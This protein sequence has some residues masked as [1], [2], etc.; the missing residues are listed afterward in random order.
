M[1]KSIIQISVVIENVPGSL[2]VVS[3]I[4]GKESINI[5][6]ITLVE[7]TDNSTIRLITDN[8]DKT[9]RALSSKGYHTRRSEVIAV[10][11]PDHPGGLNAV[12]KPLAAAGIN[13]HYLYPYLR[14]ADGNAIIL[15]RVSDTEKAIQVLK[16]NYVSILDDS[17]Y[18]I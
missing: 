11:T 9:E 17:I 5:N 15:F 6:A 18:S 7:S 16:D 10:E 4:L 13:V 1:K 12:L 2:S 8:P 3:D 14:R